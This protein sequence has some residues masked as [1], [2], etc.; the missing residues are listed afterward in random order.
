LVTVAA[1][2]LTISGGAQIASTTAGPGTGGPVQVM[3]QG[4]LSLSEP[5]SGIIASATSTASGN[6]G[7]VMVGA[8][9]IT[10]V[11]G[12]EIASTTAGTGNGGSVS[13]TTP[14]AL[15]LNGMG[16]GGRTRIAASA[17]QGSRGGAGVL[18]V[19]AG[20]LT[21]RGGAQI[22][23]STAGPGEGGDVA[24]KVANGVS[25]SGAGSAGASGI[26]TSAEPG[27]SGNAGQ[28]VLMAGGAIAL[29]GGAQV[30]SST[31]GA[32]KGGTVQVNAQ[33]PLS[34]SDFGSGIIASATSTASGNAGSVMVGAPQ[35]TIAGG[36]EIASTTAGTGN[37]GSVG[38]TTPGALV[39]N[40]ADDPN[41]QIAASATEPQSGSGGAVM[42]NANTLTIGGGAQIASS[43]AGSGNGGDVNV[44]VASDIVLPD[45][46]PQITALST[47]SGNAGSVTVSAVRLLMNNGAAISTEAETSKASGGN[48]TLKVDDFLYLVSS[49]VTTSVN[50][51]T[52]NGGNITIDPQFVVLNHSSIIAEAVE[53]HGGNITINAGQFIPSADSIVSASSQLG[54]SG[55]VVISGPRVDV[56]G[57][58]VVLSTEL[59][60]AAEVLRHSCAAQTAQPQSSLVEGGRGGLPQ[61]PDT[62]L[63]A[64]YIAG[65]DVDLN[66]QAASGTTEAKSTLQTRVH[67]TMHCG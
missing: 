7:S 47:G 49:K 4:P 3:A 55:T 38:V 34:L 61:D 59:R 56:N 14:G 5:G 6:A 43:T 22:A 11:T 29:S 32:G 2:S 10:L 63:P 42:V 8:P 9:Q 65:R 40:G 23:S 15:V 26:T 50:G 66:P 45:P 1:N 41:T 62:T 17:D 53:G 18:T 20:T 27:S 39:L 28:V 13:V 12:A 64:L 52:G 16:V 58:L 24:V 37:G 21:V 57:A 54:I 51:E 46:G 19:D 44:I 67:L 31:A 35:I 25:L 30:T 36:A 60:S 48:I 33:G